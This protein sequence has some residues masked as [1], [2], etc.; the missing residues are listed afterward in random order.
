[1]RFT[2]G[3]SA[4]W[5]SNYEVFFAGTKAEYL[6]K[7]YEVLASGRPVLMGCK[8]NAGGQH[9]VL[10]TGY[11]GEGESALEGKYFTINDPGYV[12]HKTLADQ[13]ADYP[14][15]YYIAYYKE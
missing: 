15:V 9:W 1:M 4:Y 8:T 6:E 13:W 5:P 3:G 11:T 10:I 14:N 2:A 12:R 7:V